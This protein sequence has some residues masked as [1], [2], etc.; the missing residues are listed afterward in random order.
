MKAPP[1]VLLVE[2]NPL[3]Q[4]LVVRF[5]ESNGH[6]VAV[7]ETA[8][9]ADAWLQT[10]DPPVILVD[11]SLPGEDGLSFVRRLRRRVGP[12]VPVIA[13]TAHAM[14]GD[15]EKALDAGCHAYLAKPLNLNTLL[16]LVRGYSTKWERA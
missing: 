4:K 14:A 15:C 3:N 16:E 2:D 9:D 5:L 6:K 12:D 8:A 7:A 13:V 10:H 11:V 1:E